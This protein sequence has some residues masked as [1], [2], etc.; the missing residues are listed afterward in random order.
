MMTIHEELRELIE[1]RDAL[2][3]ALKALQDQACLCLSPNKATGSE[4]YVC[5]TCAAINKAERVHA[6]ED[7][8]A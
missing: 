3:A 6:R 5:R 1:G 8:T 2:L 7:A 4:G